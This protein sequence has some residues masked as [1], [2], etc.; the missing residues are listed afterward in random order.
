MDKKSVIVIGG[1]GHA[2]VLS[3]ICL[4]N[5]F[6]VKGYIAPLRTSTI[7]GLNWLGDD[8]LLKDSFV[9][10]QQFAIGIGDQEKRRSLFKKIGMLGGEFPVLAHP[11]AILSKYAEVGEGSIICAK[12]VVN[13]GSKVGQ[14]CILNTGSQ[15]DHDCLVKDDVHLAPGVVLCAQVTCGEA[16]FVG[17]NSILK[18]GIT[19]GHQSVIGAGSVVVKD[20]PAKVLAYGSP[21]VVVESIKG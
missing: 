18:P 8:T 20:I 14:N 13:I 1:G 5:G 9:A 19:I 12:A 3:E 15:V 16:A 2:Q 6:E 7:L 4:L 17:A 11:S 21:C 10:K